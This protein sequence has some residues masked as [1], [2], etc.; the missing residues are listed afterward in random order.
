MKTVSKL[1]YKT[2]NKTFSPNRLIVNYSLSLWSNAIIVNW[3]EW[4]LQSRTM[5]TFIQHLRW[6][7]G[8]WVFFFI[9]SFEFVW[10]DNAN[11]ISI[12]HLFM[13]HNNITWSESLPGWRIKFKITKGKFYLTRRNV[14]I[15]CMNR[16]SNYVC[17]L[18]NNRMCPVYL[19]LR[20]LLFENSFNLDTMAGHKVGRCKHKVLQPGNRNPLN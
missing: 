4:N 20:N 11:S 19:S 16:N 2:K 17:T 10:F 12:F 1:A 18:W 15:K 3:L 9:F 13:R 14:A 5:Y 8:F 6:M 7:I